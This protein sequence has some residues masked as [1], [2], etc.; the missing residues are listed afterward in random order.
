[1]AT[2]FRSL[3]EIIL[4]MLDQLRIKQPDLDTKPGSVARDVTVDGPA[5]EISKLYRELRSIQNLQSIASANGRNLDKLAR[6]F[7]LTRGTGAPSTGV[8]VFTTN[9]LDTDIPITADT[10]TSARNGITYKTLSDVA[11]EA[12]KSSVYQAN[13][14]RLRTDLDLAGITDQ[15]AIEVT[16]EATTFGTAGNIGK[17]AIITQAVAGVS[18]VTNLVSFSGGANSESD[19]AFRARVL[20]IFA[21]SNTGTTLG[22]VNALLALSSIV[23][24]LAVEP[25]DTLMTRDGTDVS[26]NDAGERVIITAGT[27]GKVDLYILGSILNEFTESYIYRDVSGTGDPTNSANDFILGQRGVNPL[28][29]FQ[30]RR[31]LLVDAGTLPFQPAENIF[32]LSGSLSGA[33]FTEKYVDSEGQTKGSYE[34]IRDTG[35]FGGSPFGF[36]SI[37]FIASKIELEDESISKGSFNGEDALD[38]TDVQE[39]QVARQ[40]ITLLAE[41]PTVDSTDRSLLTLKHT[42]I[43]VVNSVLNVSTGQRYRIENQNVNGTTG[44]NNA[45]GVIQISGGTLPTTNDILQANYIWNHNFDSRVDFDDLIDASVVRTTQ[46]SLD[47]GYSNS[48]L[49]EAKTVAYSVADGYHV[50]VTHPISRLVN[51]NTVVSETVTNVAG[52]LTVTT[53]I[54]NIQSVKDADGKEV[55]YTV[56]SN[57][58]F[59]N[60]E[61]TLPTDA[62]LNSGESATVVYNV[63]DVYD[64][65]STFE[66]SVVTLPDDVTLL[67]VSVFVDYVANINSLLPSTSLAN[68]PATGSFNEFSVNS[69]LTGNQPISNIYVSSPD[70]DLPLTDNITRNLRFAPSFLRMDL[71][72][73]LS[74]GRLTIRG[75]SWT[76]VEQIIT[77]RRDGLAI[78]LADAVKTE[79]GLSTLPSTGYVA[80]VDSLEKVTLS[81]GDVSSV[82]YVYDA[83]NQDL[84]TVGY[85]NGKAFADSTLTST[86][87]SLA[88]TPDNTTNSP[89]TGD[90]VRVVCYWADTNA[91]ERVTVSA[92]GV[93]FSNDKY[94]FVDTV[95][96]DSG[97]LSL[98]NV[99][100]GTVSITNFNQP[101]SS[102]NY[103]TSYNYTAPK[104]GERLTITYNYNRLLSDALFQIED[105]RPVTAD[106]LVKA[107]TALPIDVTVNIVALTDFSGG[108]A[109]LTQSV[110]EATT[111]F[112]S[113]TTLGGTIDNDDLVA[114]LH[115]VVG[116]DRVTLRTF[117]L[118]GETGI[119]QSITADNNQYFAAGTITVVIEER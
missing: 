113:F 39:A 119:R 74:T 87:V 67:G 27:G 94:A 61:I 70:T 21:G 103:F 43:V 31:K 73:V 23:D 46:D 107:A 14:I 97:F 86:E 30:Q 55:F 83:Q 76:K 2:N 105:V 1:M 35:S 71:Q 108:D 40:Q 93:Q 37:H 15:Y 99:I 26:I 57:G 59:S 25:G 18:N 54:T 42:P 100:E 22:Y 62:I 53:A 20:G 68:L 101:T 6:N 92:S 95:S 80:L 91:V 58:S 72:G 52:K 90:S 117:N 34:L 33:N 82:N 102:S 13:A 79:L 32:S 49:K 116:V 38:F 19:D 104:E 106:V 50:I 28:L 65:T 29:D 9:V 96:V 69:S 115:N 111:N 109:N 85:S 44:T 45:D 24:V 77:I 118:E 7:G 110:L 5:S 114:A 112:L 51:V 78:D 56:A 81:G 3:D 89:I 16:V 17:F 47:W 63:V 4:A 98:S 75:T 10:L 64:S 36:D 66:N 12:S 41:Q 8:V 48:V 88:A 60:L 11:L 84:K